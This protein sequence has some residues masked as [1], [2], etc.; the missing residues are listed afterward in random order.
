MPWK[1]PSPSSSSAPCIVL[2]TLQTY[3]HGSQPLGGFFTFGILKR[4][5]LDVNLRLHCAPRFLLL[6]SGVSLRGT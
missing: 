5:T 1:G 3:S 2:P 6:W 4:K